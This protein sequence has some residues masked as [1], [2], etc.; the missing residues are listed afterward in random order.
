MGARHS[1]LAAAMAAAWEAE[2]VSGRR[3]TAFAERTV[4]P[5]TKAR[6]LVLAAFCRAHASRILARLAA[7]GRGPLPV[8]SESDLEEGLQEENVVAGLRRVVVL[9]KVA[10][11]R[12]EAMADL[13][14]T[15]AD[16]STAWVCEL[17]RGEEEDLV[18]ELNRLLEGRV[19]ALPRSGEDSVAGS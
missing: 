13:A 10:A 15:Q 1:R 4:D 19:G 5:S 9:A 17:N 2:I 8:P 6:L 16:L 12:Y 11:T 18:Y 3:L 14:R 7:L